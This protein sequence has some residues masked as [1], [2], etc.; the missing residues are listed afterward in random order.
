MQEHVVARTLAR[1]IVCLEFVCCG[2]RADWD[3]KNAVEAARVYPRIF[4]RSNVTLQSIAGQVHLTRPAEVSSQH[5]GHCN[6]EIKQ[7]F[8]TDQNIPLEKMRWFPDI[9][10]DHLFS[11]YDLDPSSD[12]FTVVDPLADARSVSSEGIE[13]VAYGRKNP[14]P[15]EGYET[16]S[17]SKARRQGAFD[18]IHMAPT[19]KSA[20]RPDAEHIVM[21]PVCVHDCFH[22]HWRWGANISDARHIRGWDDRLP[23]SVA[24]A[25]MVPL[26]QKVKVVA[27]QLPKQSNV[28]GPTL[29]YIVSIDRP[30]SPS[31]GWQILMHHGS[32]YAYRTSYSWFGAPAGIVNSIFGWAEFY[33]DLRYFVHNMTGKPVERLCWSM[34]GDKNDNLK[35]R[36]KLRDA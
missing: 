29:H 11:Y 27:D 33:W 23:Y 6:R 35:A 15:L 24:G 14:L 3:P 8:F 25:P 28:N 22:T 31:D 19:M 16:M 36:D 12:E 32:A 9:H 17:I 13:L 10:W 5:W 4:I 26:N 20:W 21:A 2:P 34:S 30:A 18:N 7:G 1:V